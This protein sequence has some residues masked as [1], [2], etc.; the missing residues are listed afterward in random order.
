M[1]LIRPCADGEEL[2]LH[3]CCGPNAAYGVP[4]LQERY[5]V[6]GL[7]FNPNIQ[8]GDEHARRLLAALHLREVLPFALEIASGGEEEWEEA[9]GNRRPRRH[10]CLAAGFE[11]REGHQRP[12]RFR[13]QPRPARGNPGPTSSRSR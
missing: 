1:K 11:V 7:F 13:P 12:I 5:R 10:C 3:I 4:A 6:T 2:L 9:A 8:P